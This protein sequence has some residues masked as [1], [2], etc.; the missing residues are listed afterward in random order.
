MKILTKDNLSRIGFVNKASGFKG[1]V[2]CILENTDE[3]KIAEEKFLFVLIEGLPVPFAVEEILL[4]DN[5]VIIK[6]EDINGE[7]EVK[8]ILRKDLFAEKQKI[9]KKA[10]ILSWK[11]LEGYLAIDETKGELG[12]I[13]EV[14]ELPQQMIAS[15]NHNGKEIL[16]PLTE[17]LIID[18]DDE[19]KTVTLDLPDGLIDLYLE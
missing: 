18:I 14:M 19:D 12:I 15:C 9:K 8:K 13:T 4:R 11:D 17:D 1:Q 6:F 3:D 7:E 16:F 2:S 5:D 10:D